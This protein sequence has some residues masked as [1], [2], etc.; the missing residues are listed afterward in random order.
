M[1]WSDTQELKRTL[2]IDPRNTEEDLKL[3]FI[4]EWI[5]AWF[6]E[7]LNRPGFDLKE[8]T[9]FY[10]GTS[11][12]KLLL[13]SRPVYTVLNG[14]SV[15]PVVYLDEGGNFGS[16]S[17]AYT[18][19][20]SQLT[21]GE[22]FCLFFD[23]DTNGDGVDDASRSGVLWRINGHWPKRSVR[24]RGL[25]SPFLSQNPGILKII[26]QGGYTVDTMPAQLR[27]AAVLLAAKL[28]Y[29]LPLGLELGSESYEERHV[30]IA[31]RNRNWLLSL[32]WPMI[33]TF[34][35]YKF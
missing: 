32:V 6:G 2:E 29:L 25:L 17:G 14:T 18:A 9:E 23:T 12:Q 13:R 16:S 1:L 22:D 20:G 27:M 15:I 11:T 30:S 24:Q 34:R 4:N 8:R 3:G 31:I 35:N 7:L 21:Y 19:T 5:G 26:Y 33:M 10:E 28:R